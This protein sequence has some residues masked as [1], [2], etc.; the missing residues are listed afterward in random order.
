MLN[1]ESVTPH[2]QV[3]TDLLETKY[4][5]DDKLAPNLF[6][7]PYYMVA[8]LCPFIGIII[9]RYGKLVH[10]MIASSILLFISHIITALLPPCNDGCLY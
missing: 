10:Y 3:L 2:M 9:D 4:K 1:Y 5:V 7:I 6:G 8:V